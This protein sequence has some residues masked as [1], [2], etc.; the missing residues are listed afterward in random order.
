MSTSVPSAVAGAAGESANPTPAPATP[1]GEQTTTRRIVPIPP[2][3]KAEP[4][5][6]EAGPDAVVHKDDQPTGTEPAPPKRSTLPG[7][8]TNE[9]APE[10][11][12][13]GADG[14]F[15]SRE[16]A[17]R[18]FARE[19]AGDDEEKDDGVRIEGDEPPQKAERAAAPVPAKKPALPGQ[20]G[21]VTFLGK[22]YDSIAQV[23]QLHRTLQGMHDPIAR[24]L[25]QTEKD[26]DF[27]YDAANKWQQLYQDA[28]AKLSQY[29]KGPQPAKATGASGTADGPLDLEALVDGINYDAFEAIAHDPKGGTRVAGQYLTR[30]IMNTMLTQ[31]VPSLKAELMK[32]ISPVRDVVRTS[33]ADAETANRVTQ[34]IN[35]VASYTTMDGNLAFPELMDDEQLVEVASTWRESGLPR[36]HAMTAQGLIQAIGLY[37]LMKSLPGESPAVMP[38][39]G[40]VVPGPE[41]AELAEGG[42]GAHTGLGRA[43]EPSHFGPE[44]RELRRSLDDAPITDRTLGFTV[45]RRR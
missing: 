23:E 16:E 29:E 40:P 6:K 7:V 24:K 43:P 12:V 41:I 4:V 44:A 8:V 19:L 5:K 1:A 22:E 13:R 21:K 36:E 45:R 14:R 2:K 26:R 30:Q 25:A 34:V 11:P 27:G 42:E 20:G 38:A 18:Q 9:D 37:R 10:L 17:E 31:I 35:E 33:Q 32:E 28:A 3:A 39:N 15:V